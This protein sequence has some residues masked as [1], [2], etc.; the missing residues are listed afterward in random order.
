MYLAFKISLA[1]L[2][3]HFSYSACECPS[4]VVIHH[5]E[6]E[7][8]VNHR[9]SLHCTEVTEDSDLIPNYTPLLSLMVITYC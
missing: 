5:L 1:R 4:I 3:L 9:N 8:V 7:A 6:S 2:F